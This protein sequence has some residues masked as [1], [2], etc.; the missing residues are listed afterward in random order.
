MI[1]VMRE[2]CTDIR[3]NPK[4]QRGSDKIYFQI[5]QAYSHA[6]FFHRV[7]AKRFSYPHSVYVKFS[8]TSSEHQ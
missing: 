7:V 3:T 5:S 4:Q 6:G 1:V 2:N 8:E